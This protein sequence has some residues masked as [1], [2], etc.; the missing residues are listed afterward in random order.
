MDENTFQFAS[1]D[2]DNGIAMR[3]RERDDSECVVQASSEMSS[4]NGTNKQKQPF[5]KSKPK[6]PSIV[7]WRDDG[8]QN[9]IVS[10]RNRCL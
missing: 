8:V 1:N 7:Q 10:Q 3:A 4:N 6:F 2:H 9:G 5:I